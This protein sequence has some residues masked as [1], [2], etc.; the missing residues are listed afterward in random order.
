MKRIGTYV[1]VA[2]IALAVG[3]YATSRHYENREPEVVIQHDTVPKI[4]VDSVPFKVYDTIKSPP[5]V[6]YLDV[7][8][9][10]PMGESTGDTIQVETKKY[11][12]V[13]NLSNGT[14]YWTAYADNLFGT[15]FKLETEKEYITTTITKTL[16]PS[17]AFFA[18]GGFNYNGGL[19]VVE[20]GIMYNHKQ[21]WQAGVVVN[22]DLTGLLPS[23]ARTSVG[24]RAY[25]KL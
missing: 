25:F 3:V 23:N 20:V 14:I 12:G 5:E 6:V 2:L 24:L 11:T 8:D 16:P 13:E 18:G 7:P 15:E 19:S 10:N 4:E 21:K 17:P 9:T 22:H 1:V